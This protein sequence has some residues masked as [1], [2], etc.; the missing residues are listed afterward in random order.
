MCSDQTTNFRLPPW[1]AGPL[2]RAGGTLQPELSELIATVPFRLLDLPQ[3]VQNCV[4]E[5]FLE[6]GFLLLDVTTADNGRNLIR[7]VSIQPLG[8]SSL[9]LCLT[10]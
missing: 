7:N 4:Y 8:G 2:I 3:E 9:A 1:I 6:Y 5:K 10:C